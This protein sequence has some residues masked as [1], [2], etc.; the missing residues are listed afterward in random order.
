LKLLTPRRVA[1]AAASSG[2]RSRS[3]A[4]FRTGDRA[5]TINSGVAVN[6]SASDAVGRPT[7]KAGERP[8]RSADVETAQEVSAALAPESVA[9]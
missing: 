6:E 1:Q 8:G 7:A 3:T 5:V 9:A 4:G 2:S